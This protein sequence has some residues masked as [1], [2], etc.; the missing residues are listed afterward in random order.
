MISVPVILACGILTLLAIAAKAPPAPLISPEV[1]PDRTVT[2]RFKD[3]GA[4]KVELDLEGRDAVAMTQD[5]DGVWS[6]TTEPLRPDLY[7]YSFTADGEPRLDPLNPLTKPNLIWQSNAV[8]VPGDPPEAWEVQRVPHGTVHHHFYRSAVI[9]DERDFF[10]Y[11]PPGYRPNSRQRYPVLYLL[12]GYSDMANAW[13]EVGKAH[14]VLDNLIA[15]GKVKP[16]L[17]VMPL[18]YGIPD[19][20]SRTSTPFSNP[21]RTKLNYENYRRALLGEVIPRVEKEYRA[22]ADREH[23]AIAGL[24]MGGSES[25]FVGLNDLDKFSS[26]GAFSSGGFAGKFDEAFP[27]LTGATAN[28]RLRLLW[29][30]C[31]KDDGL[32]GFNRNLVKWLK[33]KGVQL[34]AIETPGRHEWP[35]WRRNLIQFTGLIFGK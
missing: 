15:Q 9:G 29:I 12:H 6:I 21:D 14:V 20:A 24:S 26:V 13:T 30:A 11:T 31:G 16:M 35:V 8:L 33:G 17:I 27:G 7:G 5:A 10:V 34:T 22:L 32:V 28:P 1:H 18:G 23:R 3:P 19:F 4:T 25:L 2:F